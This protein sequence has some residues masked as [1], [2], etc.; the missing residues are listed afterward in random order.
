MIKN[1]TRKTMATIPHS[2]GLYH[3]A[4]PEAIKHAD[5]ANVAM[6]KMTIAEA[7]C[8]LG[9]ISH[10]AIKH[11]ISTG[12][13]MGIEL[14]QNSKPEFCETCANAKAARHPFPKQSFTH[15]TRYG[16]C[17]HWD[18]WGPASVQA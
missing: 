13:I 4:S 15:A 9:H 7:H 14:D 2:N 17:I 1:P 16:E 12:M 11:T 5:Y 8:K 18:L 3:L 6:V 10:A